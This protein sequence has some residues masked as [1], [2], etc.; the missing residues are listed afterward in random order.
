VEAHRF[1]ARTIKEFLL[2]FAVVLSTA[3]YLAGQVQPNAGQDTPHA[4][5]CGPQ[6]YCA[7]TDWRVEPYPEKPPAIGPADSIITDPTFGSRILRVTDGKSDPEQAGLPLY[8]PSSPEQNSW[9]KNSTM[10]YITTSEGSILLYDFDPEKMAAKQTRTPKTDL[11]GEPQFSFRQN[12][13]LFGMN[14]RDRAFEQYDT[15]TGRVAEVNALGKCFKLSADD[16]A[17]LVSVSSDDNRFVTMIGPQQ[18]KDYIVYVYDRTQGCRWYNTQSG[19][20]GGQWGSKGTISVPDRFL[21]H[22]VRIAKSGK[23]VY[24]TRGGGG[25]GH[26][27]VVWE[28]DGMNVRVCSIACSAHYALGYSHIIGS[29]ELNHPLDLWLRPLD[30]PDSYTVLISGLQPAKDYW[31][32]NHLSWNNVDE[33]DS[34][35][36]CF[37]T[38]RP[39]NPDTP[40]TGPLVTGPWQNEID[41][42]ETDGKASTVWR[43]AHTYSTARNGFWSEPK[44]NVSQDGRFFMFTSD[45]EDQLGKTPKGDK[46]RTDVFIVQLR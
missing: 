38:Y 17:S 2:S 16:N 42:A 15:S 8:T 30:H 21:L 12:N 18:D 32:D 44:G 33:K 28:I 6:Y 20:I 45:W 25:I 14:R 23:F 31:F 4:N 43:F 10:F 41:C 22:N 7:R 3:A 46:Y 11:S 5:T 35:P 13:I 37:S 9:S 39:N 1:S 24:M 34:A 29:S 19:E 36:I 40:G 26:G 27:W